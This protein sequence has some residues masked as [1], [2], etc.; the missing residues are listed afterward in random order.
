MN[1]A[2]NLDVQ[3]GMKFVL[4]ALCDQSSDSGECYPAVSTIA[5]RCSMSVRAVRVH[6]KSLEEAGYLKRIDRQGRSNIFMLNPCRI[7]TPA[8]SAPLQKTTKTPADSAPT[9]A[10]SAPITTTQPSLNH[11]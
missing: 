6:I 11:K 4:I 1:A 5:V 2:W 8:D 10:D 7:C 9:P 3:T